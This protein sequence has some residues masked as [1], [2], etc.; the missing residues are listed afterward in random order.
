[1]S[2]QLPD[3]GSSLT[4]VFFVC[5][6]YDPFSG[7]DADSRRQFHCKLPER[8]TFFQAVEEALRNASQPGLGSGQ[9]SGQNGAR[10]VLPSAIQGVQHSRFKVLREAGS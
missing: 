4:T 8:L 3:L 5:H 7:L 6:L 2:G 10:L 1:M 9:R